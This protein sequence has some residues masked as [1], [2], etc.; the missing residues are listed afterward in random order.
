MKIYICEVSGTD[1]QSIPGF[2]TAHTTPEAAKADLVAWCHSVWD[3]EEETPSTD[4]DEL[5]E[6]TFDDDHRGDDNNYRLFELELDAP[7]KL[8]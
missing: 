6:T 7:V 4:E 3:D 2:I 1:E 8:D 5:I